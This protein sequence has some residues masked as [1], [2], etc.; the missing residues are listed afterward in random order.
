MI[1]QLIDWLDFRRQSLFIVTPSGRR[2]HNIDM[3][4][5]TYIKNYCDADLLPSVHRLLLV[6]RQS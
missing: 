4:T 1:E 6:L 2:I 5:E 3:H